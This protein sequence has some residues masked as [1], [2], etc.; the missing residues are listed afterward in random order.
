MAGAAVTLLNTETG[1]T[2]T[3][4]ANET[5]HYTFDGISPGTYTVTVEFVGFSKFVQEK[6]MLQQRGDIALTAILKTG[7][8]KES[9]TVSAEASMVQLNTSKLD[10]TVDSK[11]VN[12]MPQIYRTPFLL[13]QL[14]PAVEKN[15]GG[16]EFQPYHSWGPNNQ[17]VGGGAL[18]SNDLQVDGAAVGI[19]YKT[20]YVPSPDMVQEVNV[21]Q[22]AVDAEYGNSSGSNISLTLKSGTNQW[23]GTGF[24]QGQYP[25]ANAL[26]NRVYRTVNL[27]RTHMYGGTVS[28]PDYQE[29]TVQLRGLRRLGE[30][31]PVN[32]AANAAYRPGKGGRLFAVAERRRAACARSTIPGPPPP[33]AD[34]ATITRTPYPGQQDPDFLA[35]PG[36][37]PLSW[38]SCGRPTFPARATIT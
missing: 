16:T 2:A 34:G 13:A 19:G 23:H 22:N 26:E 24:Y 12:N 17:R 15:D 1:V 38:R 32:I 28:H 3:R 36:G 8:I 37:A 9:V 11:L 18:Y 21:Q 6:I 27:G 25:W 30:D 10:T 4:L 35:G 29:Q 33:R 31:R 5:G 14:D 20:G 7:D